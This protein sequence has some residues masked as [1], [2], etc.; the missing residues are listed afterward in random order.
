M[1]KY[2]FILIVI[3]ASN[4]FG[5]QPELVLVEGGQF[6]M[7]DSAGYAD[8]MPMHQVFLR[9][10]YIGKYEVTAAEFKAYLND[11]GDTTHLILK[12]KEYGDSFLQHIVA[13]RMQF[14]IVNG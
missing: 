10:F 2:V 3:L 12:N 14:P 9:S 6:V 11:I 13:G 5:Q 4:C 1:L 7:G 8:E